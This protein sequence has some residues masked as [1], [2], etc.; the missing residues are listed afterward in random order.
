[1][2]RSR[3]VIVTEINQRR[4]R[5]V[6]NPVASFEN[7]TIN[8]FEQWEESNDRMVGWRVE[9]GSRFGLRMTVTDENDNLIKQVIFLPHANLRVPLILGRKREDQ[10]GEQGSP[11]AVSF[12]LFPG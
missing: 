3:R 7:E 9:N 12:E 1:M 10:D 2:Q 11:Y 6:E 4:I 8:C 5:V